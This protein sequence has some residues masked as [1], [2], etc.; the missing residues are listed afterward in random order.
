L[1]TPAGRSASAE[2]GSEMTAG[3][4]NSSSSNNNNDNNDNDSALKPDEQRSRMV[5]ES[6]VDAEDTGGDWREQMRLAWQEELET[7]SE[8]KKRRLLA[9]VLKQT[10]D[11]AARIA[12][13]SASPKKPIDLRGFTITGAKAEQVIS[14]LRS[15]SLWKILKIN[16][17]LLGDDGAA[18]FAEFLRASPHITSL[19]LESNVAR[20]EIGQDKQAL[21]EPERTDIGDSGAKHLADAL[22]ENCPTLTKLCL[23]GNSIGLEGVAA[24]AKLVAVGSTIRDLNLSGN[25]IDSHGAETLALA[26]TRSISLQRLRLYDCKLTPESAML[27]IDA[28][29]VNRSLQGMGIHVRSNFTAKQLSAISDAVVANGRIYALKLLCGKEEIPERE[30]KHLLAALAANRSLLLQS[31]GAKTTAAATGSASARVVLV[32]MPIEQLGIRAEWNPLVARELVAMKLGITTALPTVSALALLN[33]LNLSYNQLSRIPKELATLEHLE[34]LMLHNNNIK[35]YPDALATR[36]RKLR[37]LTL[38]HNRLSSIHAELLQLEALETLDLSYN[39]ISALPDCSAPCLPML[40]MLNLERNKLVQLP[41]Y[42]ATLTSL[43]WLMLAHNQLTLLP[44]ELCNLA[45]TLLWLDIEGN[46]LSTIPSAILERGKAAIFAYLGELQRGSEA[47]TMIKLTIVGPERAGKSEIM[48]H[49]TSASVP[50][51]NAASSSSVSRATISSAAGTSGSLSALTVA[52]GG[53][54]SGSSSSSNSGGSSSSSSSSSTSSGS[55]QSIASAAAAASTT[56]FNSLWKSIMIRDWQA[57][58]S[59]FRVWDF[60]RNDTAVGSHP[61]FVTPHSLYM[62]TF[63]LIEESHWAQLD[64]WVQSILSRTAGMAPVLIVGTF[65]DDKRCDR[66]YIANI[67]ARI[68]ER[69]DQAVLSSVHFITVNTKSRKSMRELKELTI[70][71]AESNGMTGQRLPTSYL[72]LRS[73]LDLLHQ[74]KTEHGQVPILEWSDYIRM[75][76]AVG[77]TEE[78]AKEAAGFLHKIGDLFH[79]D[80]ENYDLQ[81]YIFLDP[82]WICD[83]YTKLLQARDIFVTDGFLPHADLPFIWKEPLYPASIHDVLLRLLQKFDIVFPFTKSDSPLEGLSMSQSAPSELRD[84]APT[85]T[86]STAAIDVPVPA[87][88]LLVVSD[89]MRS[90]VIASAPATASTVAAAASTTQAESA[91]SLLIPQLLPHERPK[92]VKDLWPTFHDGFNQIGRIFE[93]KPLPATFFTRLQARTALLPVNIVCIWAKGMLVRDQSPIDLSG[94]HEDETLNKAVLHNHALFDYNPTTY[95]LKVL[96]RTG[97]RTSAFGKILIDNINALIDGWYRNRVISINLPC[98]H[99]VRERSFDPFL[100]SMNDLELLVWKCTRLCTR[101]IQESESVI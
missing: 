41:G 74:Q 36:L 20:I 30:R 80:D 87:A 78:T 34:V 46:S 32:T 27:L 47:F 81:R 56:A 29:H 96:I 61:L 54:G 100:F 65:A 79:F 85:P 62:A 50:M 72:L 58:S 66:Q 73:Q 69:L 11:E 5:L 42:I 59:V 90:G 17:F 14:L 16:S 86:T 13:A 60:M 12:V 55:T 84:S 18:V 49:L 70:Q 4:T 40:R 97:K 99:C 92:E 43:R 38:A 2:F 95:R 67:E 1:R 57:G 82:H 19:K 39:S 51:A 68:M 64:M 76:D 48:S 94:S 24:L 77:M 52:T 89:P 98:P 6:S 15:N 88:S 44:L 37:V 23:P 21:L 33:V 53:S 26:L 3:T 83:C 7:M 28:L 63:S 35:A 9:P 101:E 10:V 45:S 31:R 93:F 75:A 22:L 91:S 8:E 25:P 71:I